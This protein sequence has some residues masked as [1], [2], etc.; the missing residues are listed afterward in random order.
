MSASKQSIPARVISI[1]P[2]LFGGA[3]KRAKRRY[4]WNILYYAG[5][6]VR[7]TVQQQRT[8]HLKTGALLKHPVTETHIV[9][10]AGVVNT[11]LRRRKSLRR[12]GI[13]L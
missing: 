3:G 6:P 12:L 13:V 7:Q 8:Q 9:Y 10:S 5:A 2:V 4:G 11:I 1:D